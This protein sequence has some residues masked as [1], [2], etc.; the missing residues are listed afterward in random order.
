MSTWSTAPRAA[1]QARRRQPKS[2]AAFGF[3]VPY[4]ERVRKEVGI[5]TMAVG[6]ILEAQRR[7]KQSWRMGRPI[8]SLSVGNL[9]SIPISHSTGPTISVSMESSRI[10]PPNMD[11]GSRSEPEPLKG[12]PHRPG[13][14]SDI[15]KMPTSRDG[16]LRYFCVEVKSRLPTISARSGLLVE[17]RPGS[18][19]V[20][21]HPSPFANLGVRLWRRRKLGRAPSSLSASDFWDK[22]TS[23]RQKQSGDLAPAT[24]RRDSM[25]EVR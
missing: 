21:S 4:A 2:R 25:S 3:Q 19:P 24:S 12:S 16:C 9:S 8:S 23:M 10:G 17:R 14:S 7:L 1:F 20:T 5:A 6:I 22:S 13:S 15:H 18:M 11:G